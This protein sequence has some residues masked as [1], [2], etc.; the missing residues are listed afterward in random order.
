ME[1]I[2]NSSEIQQNLIEIQDLLFKKGSKDDAL[3]HLANANIK[4]N[5]LIATLVV[6]GDE[7]K[8]DLLISLLDTLSKFPGFTDDIINLIK[9]EE[10]KDKAS[11]FSINSINGKKYFLKI[12]KENSDKLINEP[13]INEF[14]KIY[15][16]DKAS[17]VYTNTLKLMIH[18][19]KNNLIPIEKLVNLIPDIINYF[20]SIILAKDSIYVVRKFEVILCFI[21]YTYKNELLNKE[22]STTMIKL[23]ESIENMCEDFYQYDL[24]TQLTILETM[25]NNINDENVLLMTNPN[26]N[27]FNENIMSLEQQSLRKLLFTFSKFYARNLLVNKEI[28]L[29][30]NTLAI[31][32]Q[33]FND[34]KQIQFICP[35]LTNIFH[36]TH[37]YAFLMDSANNSQFDFLN[38]IIEIISSI[39][40]IN[41][42]NVKVQIFE[43]FEKIFDF[44]EDEEKDENSENNNDK[45]K[46]ENIV[47]LGKQNLPMH[48]QFIILLLTEIIRKT[49]INDLVS[50][51]TD[52][53][54]KG[55]FVEYLYEHFKKNDLPDYELC[56]L[57]L[58]YY[59]VSDSNNTKV[60]LS[61][62]DFVLYLL[63]RRNEKPHEV[64]DR[65]YKVIKRINNKK[66]IMG[67]MSPD[68][69]RQFVEYLNKGPYS[70]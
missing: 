28:K 69:V 17:G 10:K 65:K 9:T 46:K 64:C 39:F 33:Y 7:K 40:V 31:S 50:S 20:N 52:D 61:N 5:D 21:D 35:L 47:Y 41:D 56:L 19:L 68:F 2:L 49:S 51:K 24:L 26:K 4:F 16:M 29:L 12:I 63:K 37:I 60:L 18:L 22:N 11:L 42:P 67:Q 32:F 25:E 70:N 54:I 45:D 55:K 62:F 38:N 66:D 48:N 15:F 8:I 43:V 34:K 1:R 6:D 44:G 13:F 23:K 30:K 59:I 58:I 53:E 3:N 27:F 36:N 57:R 14:F